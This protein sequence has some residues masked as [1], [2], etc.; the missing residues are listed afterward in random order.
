MILAILACIL[1][2]VAIS[3]HLLHMAGLV[4][5]DTAVDLSFGAIFVILFG[6]V[7]FVLVNLV[8]DLFEET[9]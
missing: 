1:A 7:A 5:T 8:L 4:A 6:G 2:L 3:A 9:R